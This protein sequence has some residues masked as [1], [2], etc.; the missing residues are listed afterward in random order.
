[1]RSHVAFANDKLIGD[2]VNEYCYRQQTKLEN[3]HTWWKKTCVC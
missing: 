2:T 3:S 1:V